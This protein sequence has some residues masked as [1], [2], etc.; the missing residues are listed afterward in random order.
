MLVREDDHEPPVLLQGSMA[1][2]EGA[3]HAVLVVLL[4][5]LLVAAEPARVVYELAVAAFVVPLG[6]EGPGEGR[7]DVCGQ[8]GNR[9]PQPHMEEVHQVRVGDGVVVRWV[10]E[11]HIETVDRTDYGGP[12]D[13]LP[14]TGTIDT[15]LE[16]LAGLADPIQCTAIIARGF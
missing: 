14:A 7:L 1:G 9:A 15:S 5:T 10:G 4:G 3:G 2:T 8:S 6:A 11:N 12:T 16:V 13:A